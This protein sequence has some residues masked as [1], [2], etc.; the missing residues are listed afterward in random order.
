ML[1]IHNYL[2]VVIV[3]S[4]R[5]LQNLQNY[6]QRCCVLRDNHFIYIYIHNK[7]ND[8][9]GYRAQYIPPAEFYQ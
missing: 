9:Q 1:I 6:N 3:L 4:A 7:R 5:N 2:I 8:R